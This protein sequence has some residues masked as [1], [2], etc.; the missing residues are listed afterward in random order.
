[1]LLQLKPKKLRHAVDLIRKGDPQMRQL[2][3]NTPLAPEGAE[4]SDENDCVVEF[5]AMERKTLWALYAYC[6][7]QVAKPAK[8]RCICDSLA[9]CMPYSSRSLGPTMMQVKLVVRT[10][11]TSSDSQTF[12]AAGA[13]SAP[14]T[15]EPD[16]VRDGDGDEDTGRPMP[17]D[18]VAAAAA[19]PAVVPKAAAVVPKTAAAPAATVAA[20]S[21]ANEVAAPRPIVTPE[22]AAVQIQPSEQPAPAL[23][24]QSSTTPAGVPGRMPGGSAALTAALAAAASGAATLWSS[25][26]HASDLQ[27][28]MR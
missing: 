4:P 9:V 6:E 23:Q 18:Q 24:G 5:D 17:V 25:C 2:L 28:L 16:V 27:G 21:M 14:K 15:L 20:P 8:V 7:R 13:N 22:L 19:A 1:M 26:L 3:D 10:P 11:K 12:T